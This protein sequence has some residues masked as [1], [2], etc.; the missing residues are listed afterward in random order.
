[1][2]AYND[3]REFLRARIRADGERCKADAAQMKT[4][5]EKLI[6]VRPHVRAHPMGA[7][8]VSAISGAVLAMASGPKR[9]RSTDDSSSKGPTRSIGLHVLAPLAIRSLIGAVSDVEG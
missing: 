2:S 4:A 8:A 6:D 1:M 5:V 7:V 9:S 3:E